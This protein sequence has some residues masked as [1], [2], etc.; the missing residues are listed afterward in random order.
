M[1]MILGHTSTC[2]KGGEFALLHAIFN[3]IDQLNIIKCLIQTPQGVLK[4]ILFNSSY[5]LSYAWF[6]GK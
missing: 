1:Q 3:I 4:K 6:N 2:K 5:L